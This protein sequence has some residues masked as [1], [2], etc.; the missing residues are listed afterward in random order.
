MSFACVVRISRV[1]K[2][3]SN[4][5]VTKELHLHHVSSC[6]SLLS[7]TSL[8]S[9]SF[10]PSFVPLARSLSTSIIK[11]S[12]SNLSKSL[13][14]IKS[15]PINKKTQVKG[16]KLKVLHMIQLCYVMACI[17]IQRLL[18]FLFVWDFVKID[19]LYNYS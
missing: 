14:R 17:F 6:S 10:R 16:A 4:I 12:K 2:N 1:V 9:N 8:V 19:K 15:R 3:L 18:T 13:Q 5:F 7:S 11:E